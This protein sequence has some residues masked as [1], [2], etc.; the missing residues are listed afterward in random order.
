MKCNI[1]DRV[2]VFVKADAKEIV[3]L[4]AGTL[5]GFEMPDSLK[6]LLGPESPTALAIPKIELVQGGVVWGNEIW[7]GEY[8]NT[9]AKFDAET[10]KRT[11]RQIPLAEFRGSCN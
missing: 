2:F 5:V 1:G 7:W 9:M 3:S 6:D 8:N 10:P 11:I 4:G